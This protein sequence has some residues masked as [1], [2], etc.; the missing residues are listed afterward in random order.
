M[1]RTVR[2]RRALFDAPLPPQ[3]DRDHHCHVLGCYG[4]PSREANAG[5]PVRPSDRRRLNATEWVE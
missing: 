5:E 3:H 2:D 4:Q 1:S